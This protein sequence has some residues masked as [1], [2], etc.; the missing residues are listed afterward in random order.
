LKKEEIYQIL[1]P[2]IKIIFLCIFYPE[3]KGRSVKMFLKVVYVS[4]PPSS[5][6]K[7]I[8]ASMMFR[9]EFG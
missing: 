2:K 9:P 6:V 5:W 7:L 4:L 3:Y 8:A 1:T